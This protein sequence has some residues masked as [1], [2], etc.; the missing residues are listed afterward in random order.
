[1]NDQFGSGAIASMKKA[2]RKAPGFLLLGFAALALAGCMEVETVVRVNPDGSGTITERLMMSNEI[3]QMISEMAPDGQP[4]ELLNEQELMDAAPGFGEGVT[5][6]SS[7]EIESEF[8]RGFEANYAFTDINMI[9][10]GKKPGKNMPGGAAKEGGFTTFTMQ[11]GN[12]AE[13]VIHWPV[14][15]NRTGAVE[16]TE[17]L[18]VDEST[19]TQTPEQQEAVMEMMKMA[20]KDMRMAI[21][22]DVAGQVVDSNATHL[23]G[24]RVT[25]VDIA[26]AEFL[27]SDEAMMAMVTNQDQSVADMKD[28]MRIFPGLKMEIEPEVSVL[29]E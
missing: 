17:N 15:E 24:N 3:V 12:P 9:R 25:L 2:R 19:A 8:G 22:V 6:V 11:P 7:A 26:F 16:T 21:H 14:D 4:A 28:F 18:S 13:L 10:V 27:N 23:D 5:Y 20:F 1:M 29:F